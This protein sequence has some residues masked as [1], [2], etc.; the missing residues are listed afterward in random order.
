VSGDPA[1]IRRLT[2]FVLSRRP[3]PVTERQAEILEL[4][5]HGL[6]DK[7]IA[8]QLGV[9]HRTVRSHLERLYNTSGVRGRVP[10]V[11]AW[12][13]SSERTRWLGTRP[14]IADPADLAPER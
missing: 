7:Q 14:D 6:S 5:A 8:H 4:A 11:V 10:V 9:T 2:P 1:S 3:F 12:L 13:L